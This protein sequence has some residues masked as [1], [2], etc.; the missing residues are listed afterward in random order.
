[1]RVVTFVFVAIAL[2]VSGMVGCAEA[3]EAAPP[4]TE[5]T[6]PPETEETAPPETEEEAAP[7]KLVYAHYLEPDFIGVQIDKM[8]LER[9]QEH[10]AAAGVPVE[11][12]YFTS[13]SLGTLSEL[14][15]VLDAGGCD[16]ACLAAS[17][18][19]DRFPIYLAWGGYL[20]TRSLGLARFKEIRSLEDIIWYDFPVQR[21]EEMKPMGLMALRV[22]SD[23]QYHFMAT[24]PL[25]RLADF[26]DLKI[27]LWSAA[28]VPMWEAAGC[29][30]ISISSP[31]VYEGFKRGT[32]EATATSYS[33]MYTRSYYEV[34]KHVCTA[35]LSVP[36]ALPFMKIERF[37]S[38]PSEVQEA[39][40][41]TRVESR[42]WIDEVLQDK[43]EEYRQLLVEAG[44]E[45]VDLPGEDLL[46]WK[47]RMGPQ[48]EAAL[49]QAQEFGVEDEV[50][51][52]IDFAE[53][54][55]Q[56]Y[57]DELAAEG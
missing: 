49:E 24:K 25:D 22:G 7:V 53:P 17:H 27:R 37:E 26:E 51:E 3:E 12:E 13:G 11:V 44:V 20:R 23:M 50:K 55:L 46:E 1:M 47:D 35:Y 38:L 30:P 32:L 29:V 54:I 56:K 57:E 19:A 36:M 15:D 33:Q 4:E 48:I 45:I 5:E 43:E 18:F 41:D 10:A 14:L 6:A 40:V 42:D 16:I 34:A 31:E 39:I 8:F 52:I 9:V 2:V 28:Y 21:E